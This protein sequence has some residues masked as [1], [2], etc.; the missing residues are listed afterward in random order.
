MESLNYRLSLSLLAL[1]I[2]LASCNRESDNKGNKQVITT[3]D[4]NDSS[5]NLNF[6]VISEDK[7]ETN[8]KA[9]LLEYAVYKHTDYSKEALSKTILEI[10]RLSKDKNVFENHEGPSV[11]GIYL[12]T[13]KKAMKDK[14]DWIVRLSKSPNEIE[15]DVTFNELKVTTLNNSQDNVQSE[16]EIELAKLRA[17]LSERGLEL[18]ALANVLKEIEL[19]NIH[20]A[21]AKYPD[22]GEKHQALVDRLDTQ[23]YKK[24]RTQYKVS[25]DMLGKV[26]VFAMAYCK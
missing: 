20:K 18:C 11:I 26:S 15:P 1:F 6:E 24:L 10:Y 23:S 9:Q 17:Y 8:Y 21:D 13:S 22:F 5:S 7:Y 12:F 19:E 25:D 14:A 2:L 3:E 16:D 4:T